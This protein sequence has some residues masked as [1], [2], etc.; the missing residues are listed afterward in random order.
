MKKF[1]SYIV[2]ATLAI[3][4]LFVSPAQADS[5]TTDVTVSAIS[6]EAS[7]NLGNLSTKSDLSEQAQSLI[8]SGADYSISAQVT[9]AD[10]IRLVV[11]IDNAQAP[12]RYKFHI[13]GANRLETIN[14][15]S[16]Q[17]YRI[18]DGNGATIAWLGAPWAKDSEGRELETHYEL[19]DETLVQVVDLSS[20]GIKFPVTADPFLGIDL[21]SSVQIITQGAYKNQWDCH[22]LGAP[23]IFG[24]TVIGLDKSPTWD[25]EGSRPPNTDL[26]TWV[27]THCN[28]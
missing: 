9:M 13:A 1:K 20:D 27:N 5:A 14:I 25:L 11:S 3:N 12:N 18:V 28:W 26:A 16:A 23:V 7:G 4:G 10:A 17:I 19:T 8:N 21:I 22:A 24:M 2:L 15:G 6:I